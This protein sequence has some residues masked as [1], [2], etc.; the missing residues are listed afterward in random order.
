M[1]WLRRKEGIQS[2]GDLNFN[3]IIFLKDSLLKV[4]FKGKTV[5]R[6]GSL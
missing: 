6:G 1:T 3:F 2:D 5:D 4:E